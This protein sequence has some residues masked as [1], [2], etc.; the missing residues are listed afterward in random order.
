MSYVR[1]NIS[2]RHECVSGDLHG[3][4]TEPLI[5]AL[6][7]EPETIAEFES[8]VGRYVQSESDWPLLRGFK[9]HEDLAPYDAGIVAID[10]TSRTVGF[11]TTYSLPCAAGRVRLSREFADGDEAWIPYKVPDDWSFVE[12]MALYR[13][14]RA[15]QREDRLRRAPFDARPILFGRPM[16]AYIAIAISEAFDPDPEN[17]FA[18]IHA[19]WLMS[20]RKDLRNRSPREVFLEKQAFIDFDLQTR[21]RQWSITKVSPPPLGKGSFA[22]L[23][24]GFG[25]HEWFLYYDLFRYLLADAAERRRRGGPLEIEDEIVRLSSLRDEWLRTPDPEISGRTP[26]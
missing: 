10:L 1:F 15:A 22:Y 3:S 24:A 14:T 23:N 9:K 17:L 20:R 18:D 4:M 19:D 12:S 13:G 25:S 7:A 16:I 11:D 6:T 21:S 5:A 8:A 2:D 26:L